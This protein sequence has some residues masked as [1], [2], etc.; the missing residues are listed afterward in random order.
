MC[1]A[2]PSVEAT[3]GMA[4]GLLNLVTSDWHHDVINELGLGKLCWPLL[5]KD[6]E[7]A[8]YLKSG[9]N[10]IPCYTPV[11]DYQCALLGALIGPDE[12]SLNISTGSQ[13]SRLTPTLQ[14]GDYQTRPFFGGQFLN[15]FTHIPAGW[16]LDILLKLLREL[17]ESEHVTLQDPWGYIAKET[18]RIASTDLQV[19]LNFF[20]NP[21]GDRGAISNMREDNMKVGHVFRA[22]FNH[23][24]ENYYNCALRIWPDRSWKNLVFSGGL[25]TKLDVMRQ[26][27]KEKFQTRLPPRSFC[28]GY[29]VGLDGSGLGIHGHGSVHPGC[30]KRPSHEVP[31]R[32]RELAFRTDAHEPGS[33]RK[34]KMREATWSAVAAATAFRLRFI[35][36]MCTRRRRKAV[37]A[38]TAFQGESPMGLCEKPVK[39]QTLRAFCVKAMKLAGMNEEDAGI[40][41]DVLVTTDMWGVFTHGSK[42]LRG[43]LQNFRDRR[44]DIR[45]RAEV[46]G[47][48]PGWGLIDGHHSMPMV[49]SVG[50]MEMAIGKARNSGTAFVTVRNSGHFGGAGYYA[51]LAAEQDMLGLSFTNVDPGVSVPGARVP[52]LGTNPIAYAVPAGRRA[53]DH[54]GHC[55][56]RGGGEQD[57]C[58]A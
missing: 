10:V 40:T 17:A 18:A 36:Q 11:G 12:L 3:N 48:G 22:A 28:G 8:G 31:I 47:E 7:V 6:G 32:N 57:L 50:A 55:H 19:D 2:P 21:F 58:R 42:Q 38:A 24:A 45:A 5:R 20:A 33:P 53:S 1:D 43:L 46:V 41:A 49:T 27:I 29:V 16:A 30:G 15:A 13:I 35:R 14:L 52:L 54:A 4:Y 26:V 34:M 44:M 23:M 37:A 51:H 39:P 56:Q 9:S 25:A